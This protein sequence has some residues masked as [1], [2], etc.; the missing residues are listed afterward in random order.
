MRTVAGF[1]FS[2]ALQRR[3]LLE[4]HVSVCGL[5]V[6]VDGSFAPKEPFRARAR[7][8]YATQYGR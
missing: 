6:R 7:I 1:L 4:R 2:R 3:R 5:V 8:A